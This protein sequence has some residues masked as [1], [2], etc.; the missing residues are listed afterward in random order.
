MIDY[1]HFHSFVVEGGTRRWLYKRTLM[2]GK[3]KR[4]GSC[5]V[6]RCR[7]GSE[8]ST[9]G[10]QEIGNFSCIPTLQ[11]HYMPHIFHERDQLPRQ[12]LQVLYRDDAC[13]IDSRCLMPLFNFTTM[14]WHPISSFKR[15]LSVGMPHSM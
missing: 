15:G 1:I 7:E 11:E 6:R 12:K 3:D 4:V 5:N 2:T 14:S 8:D 9:E 10:A 13:G